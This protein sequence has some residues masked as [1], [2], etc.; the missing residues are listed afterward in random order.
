LVVYQESL[1]DLQSTKYKILTSTVHRAPR[2]ATYY[3]RYGRVYFLS[4]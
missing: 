3:L 4:I 1:H 2:I